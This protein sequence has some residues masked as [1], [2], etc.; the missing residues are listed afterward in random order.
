MSAYVVV[1]MAVGGAFVVQSIRSLLKRRKTTLKGP[2]E[3]VELELV[4]RE[5]LSHNSRLFTFALPG[6][7]WRLGLPVGQHV[8]LYCTVDGKSV[9]RAYTPVT[10]DATVGV[11]K[12]AVKVYPDGKMTQYL[13]KMTV[14]DRMLFAGPKGEFEYFSHGK[15]SIKGN[16]RHVKHFSMIAGGSGITPVLQVIESIYNNEKDKTKVSLIYANQTEEDILLRET[17]EEMASNRKGQFHFYFTLDRPADDWKQGK[18]FITENMIKENLPPPTES[19]VVLMCGPPPM[20]KYAC[21]P[22]L[23]SLGYAASQRFVF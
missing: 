15:F 8:S 10:N 22:N 7:D 17:L 11:L 1:G 3:K 13:D 23:T 21:E 16:K 18:G 6:P 4:S 2:R 5:D 20:L 19:T 9:I 12:L 14:G